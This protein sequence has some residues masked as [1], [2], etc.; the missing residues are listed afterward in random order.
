MDEEELSEAESPEIIEWE[1]VL[2]F[3]GHLRDYASLRVA[4]AR[5]R[6]QKTAAQR[7]WRRGKKVGAAL[8]EQDNARVA[9]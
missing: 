3:A 4:R 2:V 8:L 1:Q 9:S 7:R 5:T 6:Q